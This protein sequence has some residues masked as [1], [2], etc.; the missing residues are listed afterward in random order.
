MCILSHKRKCLCSLPIVVAVEYVHIQS[1]AFMRT[2]LSLS[3][4]VQ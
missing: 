1:L 2:I 4:I 3:A